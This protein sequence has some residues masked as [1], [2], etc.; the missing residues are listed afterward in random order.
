MDSVFT[1]KC[2]LPM[3]LF[4]QN[5]YITDNFDSFDEH[6][7]LLQVLDVSLDDRK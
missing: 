1:M 4:K 6:V 5:G 2:S 3:N 7:I